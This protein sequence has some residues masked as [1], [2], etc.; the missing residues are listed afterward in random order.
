MYASATED[1]VERNANA[2]E[3]IAV[4]LEGNVVA[5]AG[6]VVA[7]D[8]NAVALER[9][10][11]LVDRISDW[12]GIIGRTAARTSEVI[13]CKESRTGQLLRG[14]MGGGRPI[15]RACKGTL[16][17]LL[18]LAATPRAASADVDYV[19]QIKPIFASR[20]VMCHGALK[21]KSQLRLDAGTLA[22]KGGKHGAVIVAGKSADSLLVNAISGGLN[23]AAKMP[24]EGDPLKPDEIALIRKWIDEGAK[25]PADEVVPHGP[26]SHW[27]FK[28]PVRPAV[29]G[30]A[31][32]DNA[33]WV[34]NPIDAFVA[35]EHTKRKLTAKPDAD[36]SILLR[37]VTLD[38]IGLPPTR[39]ELH[40][41]LADESADA[42]AK[43]VDRLLASPRY[44]ERW[45]R[46]WM[47]VW[48]YSDWAGYGAEVRF[49]QPHIWRWRDWIIESLNADKPYDQMVREMIAGD[50]IAPA[51]PDVLRATG[52]LARNWSL[53]N[54]VGWLDEAVEHTS[55]AFLGLTFNCAKCHDH[56]YDPVSQ[57]EYFQYRS[58]FETYEVRV[59]PTPATLDPKVDGIVR[60]VESS[61]DKPTYLFVR[62]DDRNPKKDEAMTPAVPKS[63]G[64]TFAVSKVELPPAGYYQGLRA[65]VRKNVLAAADAKIATAEKALAQ[66]EATVARAQAEYAA[67]TAPPQPPAGQA[68]AAKPFL[69]DTFAA[70]RPDVWRGGFVY[71]DNKLVQA[72]A[73]ETFKHFRTTANH[74]PDFT[75]RATFKITGGAKYHSVGFSFDA[76]EAGDEQAIYLTAHTPTPGA[77]VFRLQAGKAVYD[78]A[79]RV[80]LPVKLNEPYELRADVRGSLVNVYA[81][82]R[83]IHA[84]KLA[85]PRQPGQFAIWTYDATAEFTNVRVEALETN[86]KLVEQVS[87]APKAVP[88]SDPKQRIVDAANAL[89]LANESF[90]AK[91]IELDIAR[92]ERVALDAKIA[93]DDAKYAS[94]A[95]ADAGPL[96]LAA[97]HADRTAAVRRAE[98]NLLS[99]QHALTAVQM[100]LN[101]SDA[102]S[103]KALTD[104]GAKLVEQGAALAAARTAL[105]KPDPQYNPIWNLYPATS[106][107]RRTAVA[108]W[109]TSRENPLAARVAVNHIWMHHMGTPIVPTVF[110]FGLNGRPPSNQ[111]LLDW[112]AVE[113]MDRGWN[114]KAIHRLIVTSSAYRMRSDVIDADDA[115]RKVDPDNVYYW[116]AN[117]RR[118][119]AETVRDSILFAAGNL[120]LK[121][122]GPDLDH[123]QGLASNRR[124][125]YF[126]HAHEKQM[127]FLKVFDAASPNECYRRIE[128]VMPQQ[129]LA[130]ANSSVALA[131]SRRLAANLTQQIGGSADPRKA[132][133]K[134][135]FEQVISRSPSDSETATCEQFLAEQSARLNETAKLTTFSAGDAVTLPASSDPNQRARENLVLVL[136]NHNDFV[137]IR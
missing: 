100:T 93:A 41:F 119:E 133:I 72:E 43:V 15:I 37:R 88:S 86:A 65:D 85:T 68:D 44:G 77:S 10:G 23:G 122:S 29:P 104:A 70:A 55:K 52:F 31:D 114:M 69:E 60:V 7:L 87:P 118:M 40:A 5:L 123:E 126:R 112:L 24:E 50:E 79:T 32:V 74:P 113:L 91:R 80:D 42:Y 12:I 25:T 48:R 102:N 6:N 96:S 73:G 17:A 21:Q 47:D 98:L 82:G 134:A 30:L 75:A 11:D 14:I 115:N 67:F 95:K 109:L 59:D 62:G 53:Y 57:R 76:T 131:Q 18:A 78:G 39:D 33:T 106:T 107:G 117:P 35:A 83:L 97:G 49:S 94:P 71:K 66:N 45:G 121:T 105:D 3:Y 16:L 61:V 132:F 120:D 130:L 34:R 124:S 13:G 125:L 129:A 27:A 64:G 101:V 92:A 128:S 28:P 137:T 2:L 116:R 36:K 110:D 136:I 26:E 90:A 1:A 63:L 51:D 108:K 135:A 38:L 99:A 81:N 84:H 20:C 54:R 46:H 22:L 111:T 4:A 56:M 127:T 103:L 9:K 19:T 8:G 89:R 58:I